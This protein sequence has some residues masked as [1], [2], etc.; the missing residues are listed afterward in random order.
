[1]L[2]TQPPRALRDPRPVS[3]RV[4]VAVI[5]GVLA[6]AGC[7]TRADLVNQDRRLRGL[8]QEQ[9]RQVQSLEREVERLRADV[10]SGG[11]R[12]GGGGG[13]RVRELEDRLAALER[14]RS[15]SGLPPTEAEPSPSD[16][17]VTSTTTPPSVARPA[18]TPAPAPP[19][20]PAEDA[21]RRDV[22]REQAEAGTVNVPE[23]GAYLQLLDGVAKKDCARAI[24]QLNSFAS[25]NRESP[26]AA[27]ALYWTAR[28]Y[29]A[30]GDQNQAISKFYDVVT[31]Y[32]K[33]NK[34][35]AALLA[36]G[37]LFVSMGDNPDARLALS[38][39][40]RDYPNSE[41]AALA[42]QKLATLEN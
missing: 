11:G 24:P 4:R 15:P 37:N 36:Q 8:L 28:C 17:T 14:E 18:P 35:P 26:L 7:A 27:N 10:E 2:G 12:G 16:E 40:I 13:T 41:E 20:A 30:S 39:L 33:A 31:R 34:A 9:R 1:V 25:A 21:W 32:P 19:A 22:A 5:I 23:R 3:P 38:K 6:L 42:R 29:A